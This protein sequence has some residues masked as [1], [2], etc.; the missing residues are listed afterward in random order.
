M[1]W[2]IDSDGFAFLGGK[3]IFY[4]RVNL[5]SF[6]YKHAVVEYDDNTGV[7]GIKILDFARGE[8]EARVAIEGIVNERTEDDA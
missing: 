1:T 5:P 6:P 4:T 7:D 2:Q 8:L 3:E